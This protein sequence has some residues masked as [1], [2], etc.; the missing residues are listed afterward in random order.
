MRPILLTIAGLNSV[1]DEIGIDFSALGKYGLFG[2]F[3]PTGSGKTTILDGISLALFGRIHRQIGNNLKDI[4]NHAEKRAR[5]VFEFELGNRIFSV[6]RIIEKSVR[7]GETVASSK[8]TGLYCRQS[9]GIK[10]P[11]CESK[12]VDEKIIEILGLNR[13]D[14]FRSVVLPQGHFS[15]FLKMKGAERSEMIQRLFKL[16]KYG[17]SFDEKLKKHVDAVG[18]DLEIIKAEHNV[19]AYA[20]EEKVAEAVAESGKLHTAVAAAEKILTELDHEFKKLQ[21][22]ALLDKE[23]KKL[24]EQC[25]FLSSRSMDVK[26][27][28]DLLKKSEAAENARPILGNLR[29]DEKEEKDN[30]K[31]LF[32]NGQI[33]NE[34]RCGANEAELMLETILNEKKEK[35]DGLLEMRSQLREVMNKIAQIDDMKIDLKAKKKNLEKSERVFEDKKGL[36]HKMASVAEDFKKCLNGLNEQIMGVF[37]SSEE[38]SSLA[39]ASQIAEELKRAGEEEKTIVDTILILSNKQ[40]EIIS[41]IRTLARETLNEDFDEIPIDD[42]FGKA[43]TDARENEELN[44][45]SLLTA[46]EEL[47]AR[48]SL[49]EFAEMLHDGKPCP[50]C[51]S[52]SHPNPIASADA[53]SMQRK[54]LVDKIEFGQTRLKRLQNARIVLEKALTLLRSETEKMEEMRHRQTLIAQRI[55]NAQ[56]SPAMS[57]FTLDQISILRRSILERDGLHEKFELERRR[58]SAEMSIAEE[59]HRI[60]VAEL[61]QLEMSVSLLK[62]DIV[63][64]NLAL[65]KI[66]GE[67]HGVV[68]T[69][70]PRE[71]LERVETQINRIVQTENDSREKLKAASER[72]MSLEK[73]K[74]T[75]TAAQDNVR[76]NIAD[77]RATIENICVQCGFSDLLDLEKSLLS[78]TVR[79]SLK[80]EIASHEKLLAENHTRL[81][82]VAEKINGRIFD[83]LCFEETRKSLN[84]ARK[85]F[86][87]VVGERGMAESNLARIKKDA[88]RFIE[89]RTKLIELER[90]HELALNLQVVLK[91]GSFPRFLSGRMRTELTCEASDKLAFLS[92]GRYRL[93]SDHDWNF[94]V[95]DAF[96]GNSR[97]PANTLSGGETFLVSLALALALSSR[98]QLNKRLLGFFFLDEGF[99][100][101]DSEALEAAFSALERLKTENRMIGLISHVA[102]LRERVPRFLEVYPPNHQSGTKTEIR[103]SF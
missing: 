34:A 88:K 101:L 3:G 10:Q 11:V 98:I 85:E 92:R 71:E 79:E 55:M 68:K 43:F 61:T 53:F 82:D 89:L 67:I 42:A 33:L 48:R 56:N 12:H 19:V 95:N 74:T 81:F 77:S 18:H 31:K 23:E 29:R 38:R 58:L 51:G 84:D 15:D 52:Q 70:D 36:L 28:T 27:K 62:N 47:D 96:N 21:E 78:L 1:R 64:L 66:T 7:K 44:L 63:H 26:N 99:G 54:E 8:K 93:D 16:D 49:A 75:L 25:D 46:K 103:N 24:K 14:F 37:V 13:D 20:S 32:R 80:A 69:A 100:T 65:E 17:K 102:E 39:A 50:L 22:L 72:M 57:R 5:V 2:I 40:A 83:P 41:E 86:E 91:G 45:K 73:E 35:F 87:K 76:R 6:E 90:K 59:N 9:D 94:F 60:L 97:R 30:E 4:I